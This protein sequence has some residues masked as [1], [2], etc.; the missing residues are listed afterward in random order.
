M[1]ESSLAPGLLLAMPQLAP[2]TP[3]RVD[4]RD[5]YEQLTGTSLRV[6]PLCTTGQM[7]AVET[8]PACPGRQR[9]GWDSS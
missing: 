1:H 7:V 3:T 5:R 6:C 2:V 4:Y 9:P 8:L